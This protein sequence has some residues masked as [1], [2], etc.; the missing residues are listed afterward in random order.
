MIL[1]SLRLN[2]IRSYHDGETIVEFPLGTVLFEGDVG[3]GKSTLLYAV[4][5]ALFGFGDM[6]GSYLLTEG[7]DQGFVSLRF[8][9]QGNSFEV[10]RGLKRRKSGVAQEDCYIIVGG[11]KEALSPSDLKSRVIDI[12]KFNEPSNPRAES[13]IFRFAIFTPQEQMKEIVQR[14]V[15]ER[16]QTLRRV[17]GV[18]EY[19]VAAD[20]SDL[21]RNSVKNQ[22]SRLLGESAQLEEKEAELQQV[23]EEIRGLERKLPTLERAERES[24]RKVEELNERQRGLQSDRARIQEISTKI[25]ELR[26][27]VG[28]LEKLVQTEQESEEKETLRLRE[29]ESAIASFRMQKKPEELTSAEMEERVEELRRTIAQKK[30]DRG[31]LEQQLRDTTKLIQEGLCPT[32]GQPIDPSA[33]GGRAEHVRQDISK[34]DE[35]VKSLE[36]ELKT[37]MDTLKETR[38][39]E[40]EKR[41]MQRLEEECKEIRERLENSA[42]RLRDYLNELDLARKSLADSLEEASKFEA[43][44]TQISQ[45]DQELSE[46]QTLWKQSRDNLTKT[47]TQRDE[48]TRRVD[49]LRSE[50]VRMKQARERVNMMKEYEIW[51]SE[52]F[53]PTVELIERQVMLEMNARFNQEFQR[54]FSALV[55][56][57]EVSVRVNEEFTPIFERQSFEQEYDALSGGERTSIALAYRLALNVVVQQEATT[58]AGDLLILDEPTDGFSKEQLSKMRDILKALN[59][60]QV[61]L[62]SHERELEAMADHIFRVDKGEG[63]S[64]V[65]RQKGLV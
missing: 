29:K 40:E 2:N 22:V 25:P 16:L 62:V 8:L 5:F 13:L 41:S 59:S 55:D 30:E 46:A 6:S 18:E 12:L 11:E 42:K 15:E 35:E 1:E 24:G 54:F 32:C 27:R 23:E 21:L 19:K 51:L 4:E 48:K 50:I 31:R 36:K 7:K 10:H 58:G 17:F 47:M 37:A 63:G 57:P 26:A 43:I 34:L 28:R 38:T 33:F 65:S 52:Y 53:R 61:I 39:Y 64:R 56:D 49:E 44:Q 14:R 45:V 9:E 20:N 60:K 3:S